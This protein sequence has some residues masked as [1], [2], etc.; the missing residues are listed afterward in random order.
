MYVLL[1]SSLLLLSC[2]SY[3]PQYVLYEL[4]ECF[5]LS[6][7]MKSVLDLDSRHVII[8]CDHDLM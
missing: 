3:C 4:E 6:Y 7:S 2:T 5:G 8:T 1:L